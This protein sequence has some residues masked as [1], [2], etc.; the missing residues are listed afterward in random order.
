[1]PWW[2]C[3]TCCPGPGC[4]LCATVPKT[5]YCQ[6]TWKDGTKTVVRIQWANPN[7][8][9]TY[10]TNTHYGAILRTQCPGTFNFVHVHMICSAVSGHLFDLSIACAADTTPTDPATTGSGFN[11]GAL[12]PVFNPAN[13]CDSASAPG[14]FYMEF[15]T[16]N[17]AA[18]DTKC[19]AGASLSCNQLTAIVVTEAPPAGLELAEVLEARRAPCVHRGEATGELRDCETCAGRVRLKVLACAI[20][21]ACTVDQPAGLQCCATCPDYRGADHVN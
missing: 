7:A 13:T 10:R 8:Y 16:A 9:P 6:L 12:A 4:N 17:Q 5:L 1:V 14:P 18:N 20:Y 2:P 11:L 3:S 21:G 15:Q 19:F